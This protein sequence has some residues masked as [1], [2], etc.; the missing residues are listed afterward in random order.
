MRIS[1]QFHQSIKNFLTIRVARCENITSQ[2]V[3]RF[4][5]YKVYSKRKKEKKPDKLKSFITYKQTK[6]YLD[7]NRINKKI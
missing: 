3:P 6:S 1:E 5:V 2:L 7:F 4:T